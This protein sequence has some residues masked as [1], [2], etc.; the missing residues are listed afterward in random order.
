PTDADWSE[1][2]NV[3]KDA[4]RSGGVLKDTLM[5]DSVNVSAENFLGFGALP[6]GYRLSSG[7]FGGLGVQGYW[8]SS[9]NSGSGRGWNRQL[10][11]VSTGFFRNSKFLT[12][13]MSVRC[14]KE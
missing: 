4:D 9:T 12:F 2:E 1:L 5:W 10:H 11:N 3:L 14:I 13:G 6:G 8:W 7:E